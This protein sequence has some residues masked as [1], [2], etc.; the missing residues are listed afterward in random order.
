MCECFSN[1]ETKI[2]TGYLQI[3]TGTVKLPSG[4]TVPIYI[5]TENSSEYTFPQ[6]FILTMT[7][8]YLGWC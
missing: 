7:C 5:P 8:F 2:G 4:M 1:V 3:L 6:V